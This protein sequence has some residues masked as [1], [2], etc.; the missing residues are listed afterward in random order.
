MA[1]MFCPNDQNSIHC[2]QY[3]VMLMVNI[4]MYVMEHRCGGKSSG[5]FNG[6]FM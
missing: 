4:I 2:E 3:D 1:P 6:P 5:G